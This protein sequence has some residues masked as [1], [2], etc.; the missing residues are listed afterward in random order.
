M[1]LKFP[2]YLELVK[3]FYSNLKIQDG[4]I[5][6]KVHGIS[7]II[8]Q[9][10][11]FSLTKLPSQGAPFDGTI[12]DDWKFDYSSHDARR[13]VCNDQAE[14]TGRLL[15]R[16]LTFDY[17]IMHY[18][19]VRILLPRSSNL[20]QASKEDLILMWDFLTGHQIDWAHLVRYRMHKALR[21]N[22]PL[23]YPQLV[24]L[25]LR[26]FQF[27]LDDEPFVQVKRSF[28]IGAGVVTSFGYRKDRNGQW[29]KKDALPT[30]DERTPSP[31]PQRDDSALMTKV[32]SELRGLRTYVGERFD[33]LDGPFARMD[34]RLTQFEED[35]G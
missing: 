9:S 1:S 30:Q 19:I 13:M 35:V 17:R 16:S 5:S 7:M 33:S 3:V 12:V 21:A 20:A 4:I 6:S 23:P 29:L 11:F 32:L 10:L 34:I 22:A 26:H 18:I 14:M 25:F 15:A 31:P 27:P 8:D 24:T 2:Y 28:A